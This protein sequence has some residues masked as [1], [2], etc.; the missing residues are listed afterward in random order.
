MGSLLSDSELGVLGQHGLCPAQL[1]ASKDTSS[2]LRT[3]RAHLLV[4]H[5]VLLPMY[6]V[7]EPHLHKMPEA[8]P[9]PLHSLVHRKPA[10][11]DPEQPRPSVSNL[12]SRAQGVPGREQKKKKGL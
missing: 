4:A 8:E 1:S 5:G 9:Q 11:L 2:Y 6:P 7:P 10:G 12:A 3:G